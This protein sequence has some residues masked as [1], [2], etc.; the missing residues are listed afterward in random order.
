MPES[1][2]FDE[3]DF[4]RW[5]RARTVPSPEVA[6]GVG[7]DCA[8]LRLPPGKIALVTTDMLVAGIHYRPE[9]AA[10]HR[11]GH[12]AIARAV[13]DIAAMA[14]EATAV[15]V[16]MAAPRGVEPARL[17][18]IFAGMKAAADALDIRIVGGDI[19]VGDLPLTLTVTVIGAVEE[20]KAVLRSGARE[21]DRILVTGEL[22]GSILGRNL[23]FL[24][25][26]SEAAWLREAADLHAMIDIS[27]GLASDAAHIAEDS[28]VGIV[29]RE[30][31]IPIGA[32]ARRL[33]SSSGR[34]A[35][36]H[37]LHDGEDYELLFAAGASDAASLVKRADAPVRIACIGE[38]V[39]GSGL[40]I[41]G[42]DGERKPLEPRGWVHRLGNRDGKCRM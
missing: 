1:E 9:D 26:L 17:K 20:G 41:A 7:D 40:W 5:I 32:A 12:K 30:D 16:A 38:V 29:L 3:F 22:G 19:A 2:A 8:A 10:P 31:A 24:P 33:A 27:D 18:E 14:G 34:P 6:V 15:V 21:G 42:P 35:L 28:A 37:A 11:I 4:I 39:G 25:R 13:S 36:E 23:D